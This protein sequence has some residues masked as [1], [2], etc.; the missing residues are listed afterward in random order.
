LGLPR[1]FGSIGQDVEWTMPGTFRLV[2]K[3]AFDKEIGNEAFVGRPVITIARMV[4][5][6][7]V[8]IAEDAVRV[9]KKKSGLLSAVFCDVFVMKNTKIK[10]LAS[11]LVELK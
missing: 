10:Q 11:Y 7:D 4:E 8:V 5:E 1:T 9:K 6:D 3:D 2:G